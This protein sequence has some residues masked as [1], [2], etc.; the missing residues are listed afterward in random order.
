MQILIKAYIHNCL[1]FFNKSLAVHSHNNHIYD[2]IE[3]KLLYR[4]NRHCMLLLTH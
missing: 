1:L 2:L 3:L 4:C